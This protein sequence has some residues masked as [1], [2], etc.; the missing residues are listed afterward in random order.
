MNQTKSH[1][2]LLLHWS[3]FL[4]AQN[5]EVRCPIVKSGSTD[6]SHTLVNLDTL[7]F[8]MTVFLLSRISAFAH[9]FAA[10]VKLSAMVQGGV[11]SGIDKVVG[12]AR[13]TWC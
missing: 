5:V 7:R 10:P 11:E 12:G 3:V 9:L 8:L 4:V 6:S 2:E 1:H 13:R